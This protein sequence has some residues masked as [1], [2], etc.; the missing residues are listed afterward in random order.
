MSL[1]HWRV[2]DMYKVSYFSG[3]CSK[4]TVPFIFYRSR[5]LVLLITLCLPQ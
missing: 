5:T 2:P 3:E 4:A 1:V